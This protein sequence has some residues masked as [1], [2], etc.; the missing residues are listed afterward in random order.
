MLLF[1]IWGQQTVIEM[2]I[3][4]KICW[5]TEGGICTEIKHKVSWASNQQ[6]FSTIPVHSEV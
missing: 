6:T 2:I 5:Q 1:L 3:T 4:R